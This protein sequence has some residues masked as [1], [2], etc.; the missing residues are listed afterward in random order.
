MRKT[1]TFRKA[2]RLV[3]AALFFAVAFLFV[4]QNSFAQFTPCAVT[5]GIPNAQQMEFGANNK[6]MMGGYGTND[7]SIC[8]NCY[9]DSTFYGRARSYNMPSMGFPGGSPVPHW[10]SRI[11]QDMV[12][13]V[14]RLQN[15][16]NSVCYD[17]IQWNNGISIRLDGSVGIGTDQTFGYKLAVNGSLISR[18]DVRVTQ[19]GVSWPDYV[20]TP[21]Y[22]L[23][24]L[25]VLEQEIDSIG[26]LPEIP[27]ALEVE[28]NGLS[29]PQ[30]D[31]LL[32]KK[33]EELTLYTIDQQKQIEALKK[34]NDELKELVEGLLEKKE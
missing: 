21:S 2:S 25:F 1:W 27:S 24:P 5:P 20:F 32:L 9:S 18:N 14:F 22:R 34:Q 7:G 17:S 33:V 28:E 3:S 23:K 16:Q 8:W 31:A 10:S 19:A 30:M 11:M 4:S 15:G 29:L 12:S 13:G 26:H 6:I